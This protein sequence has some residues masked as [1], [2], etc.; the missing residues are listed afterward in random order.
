MSPTMKSQSGVRRTSRSAASAIL[1]G[2]GSLTRRSSRDDRPGL[3][4]YWQSHF[5]LPAMHVLR[6]AVIVVATLAWCAAA[7]K[8]ETRL[9]V[10][11][12]LQLVSPARKVLSFVLVLL[13]SWWPLRGG[14]VFFYNS[15]IFFFPLRNSCKNSK[16]WR[17]TGGESCSRCRE[18]ECTKK[19]SF[20]RGFFLLSKNTKGW[21]R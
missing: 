18:G 16:S 14:F 10:S 2:R 5:W 6:T 13:H 21:G 8:G 19:R 17:I 4:T 1:D 11:Q 3:P 20:F 15:K 7:S 9:N 12:F